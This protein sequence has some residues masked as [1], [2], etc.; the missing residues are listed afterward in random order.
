M[1][2]LK[3]LQKKAMD[4]CYS[5]LIEIPDFM[6]RFEYLN[7]RTPVGERTFGGD[8]W[9]NQAFYKSKEWLR[10]RNQVIIRD[11]GCDMAHPDFPIRGRL[12]VH[13][14]NSITAKDIESRADVLFDMENLILVSNPT[15][16]AIHY[17][18]AGLLEFAEPFVE[19][20]PGDTTLW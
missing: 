14:I 18:D 2:F 3:N 13:H 19:R 10:I 8:R 20:T 7:H 1:A 15:H 11:N 17:S 16:D 6:E 5:E 4:K 9:L 12:I